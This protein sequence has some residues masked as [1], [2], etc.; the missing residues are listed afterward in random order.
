MKPATLALFNSHV[1]INENSGTSDQ[2]ASDQDAHF[3]I[4]SVNLFR[5]Q[6]A[7]HAAGQAKTKVD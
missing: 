4:S 2:H 1:S 6:M 3:S 7:E 5:N